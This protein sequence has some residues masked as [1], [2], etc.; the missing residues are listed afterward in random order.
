MQQQHDRSPKTQNQRP[1]ILIIGQKPKTNNTVTESNCSFGQNSPKT[2]IHKSLPYKSKNQKANNM[3][4][5]AVTLAK[6][7]RSNKSKEPAHINKKNKDPKITL[8]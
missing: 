8:T 5:H 1:R 3:K 6:N 4:Y 2:R 7:Q